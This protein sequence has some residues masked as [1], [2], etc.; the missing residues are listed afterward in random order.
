MQNYNANA[1][2]ITLGPDSFGLVIYKAS[3]EDHMDDFIA[4][5]EKTFGIQ[6]IEI[7]DN[8]ALIASVGRNMKLRPGVSGKLFQALGKAR[9]NIKTI[10]QQA[11]E[12]SIIV[13]VD[14][15]MFEKAVR[16]L[17]EGFTC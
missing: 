1:E 10:A 6:N 8:I 2:H 3:L 17:Y 11:E 14:N 5:M 15:I 9:I 7:Q 12:L 16:V 13:G 4:S